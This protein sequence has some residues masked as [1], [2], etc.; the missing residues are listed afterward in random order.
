MRAPLPSIRKSY[1]QGWKDNLQKRQIVSQ[2]DPFYYDQPATLPLWKKL[3]FI[4]GFI[5]FLTLWVYALT[6]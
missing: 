3:T 1:E 6:R 2:P 4:S 5:A